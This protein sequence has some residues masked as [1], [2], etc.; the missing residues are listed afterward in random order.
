LEDEHIRDK[1]H[2]MAT[3]V[4][5]TSTTKLTL[6]HPIRLAHFT[7]FARLSLKMRLA[8]LGASLG[9][10]ERNSEQ[11]WCRFSRL[12]NIREA[13]SVQRVCKA[14]NSIWDQRGC[15]PFGQV[16]PNRF[17]RSEPKNV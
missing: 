13:L 2:E 7:R 14:N 17:L 12:P 3:D 15:V 9:A 5:A 11:E 16:S 8:S 6:F 4:M 1:V 10:D